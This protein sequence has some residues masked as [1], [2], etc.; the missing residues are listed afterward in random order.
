MADERP[1][2]ARHNTGKSIHQFQPE[3]KTLSRKSERILIKLYR[4]NVLLLFNKTCL[5]IYIYIYIYKQLSINIHGY[6]E[7]RK[8]YPPGTRD[9]NIS[10]Q[11]QG[12]KKKKIA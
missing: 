3:T 12:K 4:Q 6:Q 9:K 5:Y 7:K 8:K 11:R 1:K 10:N 2:S